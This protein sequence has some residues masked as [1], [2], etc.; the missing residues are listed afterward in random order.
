M[1]KGPLLERVKP[2]EARLLIA[3]EAAK[4][5]GGPQNL[6]DIIL[7]GWLKAVKVTKKSRYFDRKDLDQCVDRA[8]LEGRWPLSQEKKEAEHDA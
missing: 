2:P 4:Y 1:A 3:R 7:A 6:N 8:K 5:V